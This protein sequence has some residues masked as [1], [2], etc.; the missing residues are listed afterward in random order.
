MKKE[1][2]W[3][4]DQ[5]HSVISF[6]VRHLM[7]SRVKGTFTTFDASI[8][9]LDKDFTTVEIDLQIEAVSIST[10]DDKRDE[11]LRGMEFF[12]IQNHP[13]ISFSASEMKKAD[14]SGMQQL[15][16]DLTMKGVTK[17]IMLFVEA[18]GMITDLLGKER[19]GFKISGK[20]NRT[21]WGL[22]WNQVLEA[23]GLLVGDEVEILCDIELINMNQEELIM[24][25]DSRDDIY[26][27]P[28]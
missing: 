27:K 28:L 24:D 18:G 3:K 8:N 19:A 25:L 5:S 11:H 22:Q 26:A 14:D 10:G 17:R 21:D 9:T 2:K 23:G 12:D 16:G 1:T 13:Q 6:S 4:L 15:W 20:I 7:I